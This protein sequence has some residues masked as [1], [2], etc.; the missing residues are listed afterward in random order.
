MV[1][2]HSELWDPNQPAKINPKAL[3]DLFYLEAALKKQGIYTY[4]SF[5]FPV[6]MDA[7]KS[8]F[9]DYAGLQNKHPF[10][11]LYFDPRLQQMHRG[12]AKA[13]LD[14]RN[15]YTGTTLARDPAVGI[16][17]MLNEDSF[18]FWT[19]GKKNIPPAKWQALE[20]LYAR[21]L[22]T[23][24]GSVRQAYAAWDGTKAAGDTNDRPALTR[25]LR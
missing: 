13:I 19:F 20:D 14:T 7:S 18:F 22:A 8:G 16:V 6:W 3:D 23:K 17:E 24:Y 21:W 12:W 1:R 10:A 11:L 25:P 4:V 2:F 9:G 15:P 5:Y